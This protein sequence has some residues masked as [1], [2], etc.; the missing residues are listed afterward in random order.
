MKK[1][2]LLLVTTSF[3]FSSCRFGMGKKVKGDGNIT[4]QEK[5]VS[6]FSEVDVSG[7]IDLYVTLGDL[8][9]VR[10]ETDQNLQQYIVVR[11]DGNKIHIDTKD[12]FRLDPTG[13][14]KVYVTSPSYSDI[15]VSGACNIIGENKISGNGD[16]SLNVSGAGGINMEVEVPTLKADISGSGSIALKGKTKDFSCDLTGAANAKCFD[17]LT[18]NT[19]IEISGA[20]DAEVF[21]SIKL[22]ARVSG[23]GSVKYKGGAASVNQKV[24][25]AGSVSKVE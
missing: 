25:G 10:I 9:P 15:D 16:L 5:Q 13:K 6:S 22:D 19:T 1:I 23:A 3:L 21:A 14:L 17:L 12:G 18:E 20:G 11:Q 7:A 4:T 2:L 8:K 24:S